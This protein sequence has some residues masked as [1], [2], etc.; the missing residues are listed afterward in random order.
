MS[1][2]FSSSPDRDT[3]NHTPK[4]AWGPHQGSVWAGRGD[5]DRAETIS[6][7]FWGAPLVQTLSGTWGLNLFSLS[8]WQRHSQTPP[9]ARAGRGGHTGTAKGD[10]G[11]FLTLCSCPQIVP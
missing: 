6:A 7:G 1:L 3:T 4:A 11:L 8:L 5:R 10:T 2:L 9:V